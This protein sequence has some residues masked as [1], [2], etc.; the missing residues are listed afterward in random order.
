[1]E[2]NKKSFHRPFVLLIVVLIC[3]MTSGFRKEQAESKSST[4]ASIAWLTDHDQ[5][6][7]KARDSKKP[8]MIVFKADWCPHCRRLKDMTFTRIDVIK[9]ASSFIPLQIDIDKYQDLA[10]SY[11]ANAGRYG[12]VGVPNI[13]FMTYQNRTLKHIIGF[14]KPEELIAVMDSVLVMI[15]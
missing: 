3:L 8:L 7:S 11:N 2:F 10:K 5:A 15:E 13:L 6:L 9:K 1:M 12:G 14:K 4:T